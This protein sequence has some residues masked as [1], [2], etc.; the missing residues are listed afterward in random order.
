[1]ADFVS[2]YWSWFIIVLVA[3]GFIFMFWLIVWQSK[4]DREQARLK[5]WGMSGMRILQN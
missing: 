4:D 1:M 2:N 3:L 5:P